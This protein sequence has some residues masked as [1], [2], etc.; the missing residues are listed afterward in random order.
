MLGLVGLIIA[1]QSSLQ[2]KSACRRDIHVGSPTFFL[3]PSVASPLFSFY[4]RYWT[5]SSV[6]SSRLSLPCYRNTFMENQERAVVA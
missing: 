4:N 5:Q 2:G 1:N 6:K 3:G